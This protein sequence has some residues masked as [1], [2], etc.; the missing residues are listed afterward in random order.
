MKDRMSSLDTKG[1]TSNLEEDEVEELHDISESLHFL[2]RV[3][4]SMSWLKARLNWL[5]EGDANTKFF[6]GV[7]SS[8]R[9]CNAIQLPNVNDVQIEG[10]HNIRGAVW[11]HFYSHFKAVTIERPEVEDLHFLM[12]SVNEATSLVRP[13]T[14]EEVKAAIWNCDSFKSPGPDGISIG[15]IKQFWPELKVDFMR[16]INEFHRNGKLTKG[17]NATFISFIP[18]V[19]SPQRL[20]DYR[21]ISL[22]GCMYKVLAKVLASRLRYVI[23]IVV[24]DS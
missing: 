23:I 17:T 4:A 2:S 3:Q 12:L 14:L 20:N 21:P 24:S 18:K 10:V 1:E 5:Q 8:R 7:M 19:A 22:V 16:F 13:F 9:R 15:F 6:H 11:N